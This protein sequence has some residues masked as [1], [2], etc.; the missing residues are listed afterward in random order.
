MSLFSYK[1]DKQATFPSFLSAIFYNVFLFPL[2]TKKTKENIEFAFASLN[3]EI[4]D[5]EMQ[6][7]PIYK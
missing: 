7:A 4:D 3:A 5:F 6:I 1:K 2:T